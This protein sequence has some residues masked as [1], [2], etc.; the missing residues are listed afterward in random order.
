MTPDECGAVLQYMVATWPHRELDEQQVAVWLETFAPV[1]PAWA[2][3]AIRN[4]KR[5]KTFM[6]SHAEFYEAVEAIEHREA[7]M[8]EERMLAEPGGSVCVCDGNGWIIVDRVG[9]GHVERCEKCNPAPRTHAPNGE[10]IEHKAG[11]SCGRC[12]YGPKRLRAIQSGRDGMPSRSEQ[13]NMQQA[14]NHERVAGLK[15]RLATV[16]RDVE[17]GEF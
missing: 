16:G 17:A 6:P 5:V 4:L 10:P 12:Y 13:R 8:H 11:C 9:Q 2:R 1:R 15:D 7:V 3:E 14:T